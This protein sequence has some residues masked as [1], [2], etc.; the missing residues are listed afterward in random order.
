LF[1][2]WISYPERY[3]QSINKLTKFIT[4]FVK[5]IKKTLIT[6]KYN[7]FFNIE[8]EPESNEGN[9]RSL[10]RALIDFGNTNSIH[11]LATCGK[12]ST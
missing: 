9:I 11:N 3:Y 10:F 6:N 7:Y 12:N 5:K 1:M 4:N 2:L 8:H